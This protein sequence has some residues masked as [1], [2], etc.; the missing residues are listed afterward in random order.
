MIMLLDLTQ[1]GRRGRADDHVERTFEP[2]AFDRQ[3]S[4]YRVAAPVYL[5]LN[6][7]KERDVY[8]VGGRLRT[9][10][11]L[12]CGRCLEPFEI[13][14]DSAFDLRYVPAVQATG[15]PEREISEDD[16]T[17][18]FYK[19]ETLDLGELTH[20]Q[21]LLALPMK[22]L[23]KDACKG[24]CPDCGANLNETTCGCAPR[25]DDPRLAPLRSLLKRP[26]YN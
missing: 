1:L 22:P 6:V 12:E 13:P 15:E 20:E 9:R 2:S 16:L 10:L 17:T 24:L 5:R 23:C 19:D 25:W 3:D 14:I 11:E 7:H 21:F 26:K 18:A 8:R 4:D